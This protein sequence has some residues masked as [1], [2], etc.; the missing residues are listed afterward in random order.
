[1]GRYDDII[2][3][4]YPFPSKSGR[5]RMPMDER[6]KIFL[7]FSALRGYEEAIDRKLEEYEGH[8][9]ENNNSDS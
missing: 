7:P 1:M 4:P 8:A 3:T 9:E 5:K 6:A 2:D